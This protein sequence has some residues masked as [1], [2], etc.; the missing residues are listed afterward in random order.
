MR[1]KEVTVFTPLDFYIQGLETLLSCYE[2]VV[3]GWQLANRRDFSNHIR[4]AAGRSP[5]VVALRP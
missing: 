2:G 4:D 1:G 5:N 3:A